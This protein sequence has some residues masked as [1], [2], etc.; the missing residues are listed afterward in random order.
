MKVYEKLLIGKI[1]SSV[2]HQNIGGKEI[3]I[4]REM[5]AKE[6]GGNNSIGAWNF[7]DRR[8]DLCS[9]ENDDVIVYYGHIY[10]KPVTGGRDKILLGYFVAADEIDGELREMPDGYL[11]KKKVSPD[12]R[13]FFKGLSEAMR[14][15]R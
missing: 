2:K 11:L 6:A 4:E 5:T 9:P 12:I 7:W 14:R 3:Y 15:R 1:K 10:N 8:P 13:T